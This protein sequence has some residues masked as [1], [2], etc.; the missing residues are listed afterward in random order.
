MDMAPFSAVIW[1]ALAF[2]S[3]VVVLNFLRILAVT[4]RNET[5]LHNLRNKVSTLKRLHAKARAAEED[6]EVIEVDEY[7]EPEAP[8]K[9]AA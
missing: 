8:V 9:Q 7:V 2:I 5:Y 1:L 3:A 6:G 4:I